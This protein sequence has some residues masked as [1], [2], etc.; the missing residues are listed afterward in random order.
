MIVRKSTLPTTKF[1][2]QSTK[3]TFLLT[4]QALFNRVLEYEDEDLQILAR[5]HIPIVT[6]QLRA[7]D[8]VREQQKRIK[9]G[10]KS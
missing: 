5:G 3:Y 9:S 2:L 8:R 10:K 4:I 7:L 1:L 6:L